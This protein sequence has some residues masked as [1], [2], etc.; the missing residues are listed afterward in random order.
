MVGVRSLE[1]DGQQVFVTR[2]FNHTGARQEPSYAAP[3]FARQI[4]LIE[5]G[6][7]APTIEVGNL[8]SVRDPTDVRDV[9]RAYRDIVERGR[10]GSVYNVCSGRGHRIHEVLRPARGKEPCAGHRARGPSSLQAQ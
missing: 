4:A 1:E 9:V 7:M 2:S 5:A 8:A 6:R 10:P 3:G